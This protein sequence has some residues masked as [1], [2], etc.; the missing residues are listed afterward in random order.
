MGLKSIR[1]Q[2]GAA[3]SSRRNRGQNKTQYQGWREG[4]GRQG[5]RE[6][7][8]EG[9]RERRGKEGGE[10]N[11]GEERGDSEGWGDEEGR[12][13]QLSQS[14]APC[15]G[16]PGKQWNKEKT[17]FVLDPQNQNLGLR[18]MNDC[19]L[20]KMSLTRG[21]KR[22]TRGLRTTQCGLITPSENK[23]DWCQAGARVCRVWH[24]YF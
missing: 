6:G 20:S 5:R 19:V 21:L 11:R 9:G 23:G 22:A 2:H 8:E 13:T 18:E 12:K 24:S 3:V 4:R 1:W 7:R 15:Y 14:S 10:R 17:V 16:A